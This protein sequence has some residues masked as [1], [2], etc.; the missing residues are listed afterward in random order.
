M[1]SDVGSDA[2]GSPPPDV[3]MEADVDVDPNTREGEAPADLPEEGE[4]TEVRAQSPPP[5]P[6]PVIAAPVV[7]PSAV[8]GACTTAWEHLGRCVELLK[9]PAG[10]RTK[11]PLLYLQQTLQELQAFDVKEV[12]K[13]CIGEVVDKAATL[14]QGADAPAAGAEATEEHELVDWDGASVARWFSDV[15]SAL[16]VTLTF[17]EEL[18]AMD[19][20]C[21]F[22]MTQIRLSRLEHRLSVLLKL[23]KR[24]LVDGH[25]WADVHEVWHTEELLHSGDL[26][27]F[28]RS[29][30]STHFRV[31]VV[32]FYEVLRASRGVT[33]ETFQ[34]LLPWL[35]P[36]VAINMESVEAKAREHPSTEASL[37]NSIRDEELD[38]ADIGLT[39]DSL[40]L[41]RGLAFC[42]SWEELCGHAFITAV[43]SEHERGRR[44]VMSAADVVLARKEQQSSVLLPGWSRDSLRRARPFLRALLALGAS[45]AFDTEDGLVV[46]FESA[47]VAATLLPEPDPDSEAAGG[48]AKHHGHSSFVGDFNSIG[49]DEMSGFGASAFGAPADPAQA[50]PVISTKRTKFGKVLADIA[51][52]EDVFRRDASKEAVGPDVYFLPP[53]QNVASR[54]LTAEVAK[55]YKVRHARDRHRTLTHAGARRIWEELSD[56]LQ[57]F[58]VLGERQRAA[59]EQRVRSCDPAIRSE[60]WPKHQRALRDQKIKEEQVVLRKQQLL[61]MEMASDNQDQIAHIRVLLQ[62][63]AE[64]E[65]EK[66]QSVQFLAQ[67]ESKWIA[68]EEAFQRAR[69]RQDLAC[70]QRSAAISLEL[71]HRHRQRGELRTE[72]TRV[73]SMLMDL[74]ETFST[75]RQRLHEYDQELTAM[76]H[77]KENLLENLT[78]ALAQVKEVEASTD[79]AKVEKAEELERMRRVLQLHAQK[80]EK[81]EEIDKIEKKLDTLRTKHN[82]AVIF[83]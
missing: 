16:L 54:C 69:R 65:E 58:E 45:L 2:A 49:G 57:I 13:A 78:Q 28:W 9:T 8:S 52:E 23:L 40:G 77:E 27:A 42:T 32:Q 56:F 7:T 61:Q 75:N 80:A 24:V 38:L 71:R 12:A 15:L 83:T 26:V 41:S 3:E 66:E 14:P 67:Q 10:L 82:V 62:E 73:E 18:V 37:L 21:D 43:W 20:A 39:L 60:A 5:P 81:L 44:G 74:E 1:E 51:Q 46:Q 50:E 72:M 31:S 33:L 55:K 25:C 34:E 47:E 30:F 48:E 17:A 59:Y 63:V 11:M 29:N 35:L 19:E 68:E 70:R 53:R 22:Q 64:A 4:G 79:Q 6:A 76:I 36:G